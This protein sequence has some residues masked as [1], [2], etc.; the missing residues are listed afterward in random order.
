MNST[1]WSE[2]ASTIQGTAITLNLLL[3]IIPKNKED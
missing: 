3:K 2:E 1:G